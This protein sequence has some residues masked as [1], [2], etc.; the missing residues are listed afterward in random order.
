MNRSTGA[1]WYAI[2]FILGS[3]AGPKFKSRQ[4]RVFMLWIKF[5]DLVRGR[6]LG[7]KPHPV[8]WFSKS[9]KF[10]KRVDTSRVKPF[11]SDVHFRSKNF[12]SW[13]SNIMEWMSS[14]SVYLWDQLTVTTIWN[15]GENGD[16]YLSK[17]SIQCNLI[18][19][20]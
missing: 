14:S 20:K 17:N 9:I 6:W 1:H 18:M 16:I 19:L 2:C 3:M 7:I 12:S 8:T 13:T 15:T 11:I 5:W 10:P 4:K